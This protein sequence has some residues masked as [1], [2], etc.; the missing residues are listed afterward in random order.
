MGQL[1]PRALLRVCDTSIWNFAQFFPPLF[2]SELSELT[3]NFDTQDPYYSFQNTLLSLACSKNFGVK[4]HS[5]IIITPVE[6]PDVIR[7]S[8]YCLETF[9]QAWYTILSVHPSDDSSHEAYIF[10]PGYPRYFPTRA[11]FS[12]K[13]YGVR[14]KDFLVHS[15]IIKIA[16]EGRHFG[17]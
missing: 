4:I 10:K 17:G 8:E 11:I 7:T 13:L 14:S 2:L 1:I 16:S 3:R 12:L 9:T 6:L 5:A 15:I